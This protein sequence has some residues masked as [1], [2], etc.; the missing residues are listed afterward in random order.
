MIG[1]N[2][3]LAT[4]C[5]RITW[6]DIVTRAFRSRSFMDQSSIQ[7]LSLYSKEKGPRLTRGE[8]VSE[9][10]LHS[11]IFPQSEVRKTLTYL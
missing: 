10:C 3:M 7:I 11:I 2:T 9:T 4:V 1:H 6:I 5:F 8:A